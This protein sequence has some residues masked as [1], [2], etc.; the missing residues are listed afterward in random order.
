MAGFEFGQGCI[1]LRFLG[2]GQLVPARPR[3][4]LRGQAVRAPVTRPFRREWD[5]ALEFAQTGFGHGRPRAGTE[6]P[7]GEC[8]GGN[9]VPA[10]RPNRGGKDGPDC[11][12]FGEGTCPDGF[13]VTDDAA[14]IG[15]LVPGSVQGPRHGTKP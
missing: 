8:R 13:I 1:K 11:G 4:G 2:R 12:V 5:A 6:G 15:D 10:G 14:G 9:S 7:G 3:R